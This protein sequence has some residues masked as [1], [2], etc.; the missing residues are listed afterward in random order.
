[1]VRRKNGRGSRH[2][3]GRGEGAG[4]VIRNLSLIDVPIVDMADERPHRE[5]IVEKLS[6]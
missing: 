3:R 2:F 4:R 6:K 5:N 1:M